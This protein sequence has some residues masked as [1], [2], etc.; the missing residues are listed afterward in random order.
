MK[1]KLKKSPVDDRGEN[2]RGLWPDIRYLFRGEI[3]R[4][5]HLRHY[6]PLAAGVSVFTDGNLYGQRRYSAETTVAE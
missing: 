4:A 6:F 5:N 2:H 1:E 3:C